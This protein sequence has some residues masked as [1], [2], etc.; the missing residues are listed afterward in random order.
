MTAAS[1]TDSPCIAFVYHSILGPNLGVGSA[2]SRNFRTSE[3]SGTKAAAGVV[4]TGS[5]VA[6][7]GV[8]VR[9][10]ACLLRFGA[11]GSGAAGSGLAT[12]E[13]NK[14]SC[15]GSAFLKIKRVI[16]MKRVYYI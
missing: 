13:P 12:S 15:S 3:T 6:G 2:I 10:V 14:D 1:G 11:A 4:V 7:S 16:L 8:A 5:G 9:K